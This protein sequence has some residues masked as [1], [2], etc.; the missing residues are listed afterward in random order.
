MYFTYYFEILIGFE[1][2]KL[3]LNVKKFKDL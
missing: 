2:I 1:M 3:S